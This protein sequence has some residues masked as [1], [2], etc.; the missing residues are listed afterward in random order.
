M[1]ESSAFSVTLTAAP[2]GTST[3]FAFPTTR[4]AARR[5]G[6]APF[7]DILS[8]RLERGDIPRSRRP[9]APGITSH[10]SCIRP[11]FGPVETRCRTKKAAR[12]GALGAG[13]VTPSAIHER[14]MRSGKEGSLVLPEPSPCHLLA[15]SSSLAQDR[16]AVA[17]PGAAG[18]RRQR[19][20]F[21]AGSH[22]PAGLTH[23]VAAPPHRLLRA[24]RSGITTLS[25][26]LLVLGNL[27]F[28]SNMGPR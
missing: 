23:A 26:H 11:P 22:R 25:T 14:A 9:S 2:H 13:L 21:R 5:T 28:S 27:W 1:E 20:Y 3:I 24:F 7:M 6:L 10:P 19:S 4:F 17:H 8:P 16:F 12:R 15:A 18:S